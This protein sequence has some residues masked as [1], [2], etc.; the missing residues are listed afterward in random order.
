[1]NIEIEALRAIVADKG[2]SMETVLSAIESALL[3]AYRH[4]EGHEPNARIDI[5]QKTS[6]D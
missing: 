6:S 5:N 4:T 3:T 2:I 1:M